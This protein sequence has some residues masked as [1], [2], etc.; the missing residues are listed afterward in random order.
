VWIVRCSTSP[1]SDTERSALALGSLHEGGPA[2]PAREVEGGGRGALAAGGSSCPQ[3]WSSFVAWRQH[4]VGSTVRVAPH[5]HR[6]RT[7]GSVI[8]PGPP[9][10]RLRRSKLTPRVALPRPRTRLRQ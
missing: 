3:G 5:T 6:N 10:S 8:P 4:V 7:E 2:Q 1:D 9:K